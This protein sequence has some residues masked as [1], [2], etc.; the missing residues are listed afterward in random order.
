MDWNNFCNNIKEI[1]DLEK[2]KKSKVVNWE[3]TDKKILINY[4]IANDKLMQFTYTNAQFFK[5]YRK[6]Q[7]D[8]ELRIVNEKYYEVPVS[9]KNGHFSMIYMYD[10]VIGKEYKDGENNLQYKIDKPSEQF[11][12][13]IIELRIKPNSVMMFRRLLIIERE[14]KFK[15]GV[16][17]QTIFDLLKII[18]RDYITLKI[19]AMQEQSKTKFEN[20]ADALIFS[21]NYNTDIG[22]RQTYDLE[23]VHE[24]RMDNRF[25]NED[26][27]KIS[28]PRRIYKK[29]L[30]EQYNMASITE[31]PFIQYLC[32]YHIL[33]HFYEFVYKEQL[34]KIVKEQLTSPSF[35]IKKDK[36]IMK[37]IDIV[38]GKIKNDKENFD[39][40]ELEALELVL[41]KY[42]D[43]DDLKDKIRNI[44]SQLVN[45]YD[46]EKID[47]SRGIPINFNDKDNL[48]KNIAKRIYFTRNALVHYKSND[49]TQKE[50]GI[51]RP[52][53]D[54]KE[55][56][57]EV[58]LI[59]IL[60][61]EI[62]IKN[63]EI[64]E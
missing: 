58:P 17:K 52:F 6:M 57:K 32:Y 16:E 41:K 5:D 8:T 60:A 63:S 7:D 10:R 39:V 11:F 25:R 36:E 14:Y 40:D 2:Y 53:N 47:F 9:I 33:E 35:S 29:E 59:R 44:N 61:E 20:L 48:C 21:I 38:K 19:Y 62:I 37:L 54:R 24:R 22:I 13:K 42:I 45:Y 1:L 55:L 27:D 56:V 28:P 46:K 51:Y 18:Y 4:Y 50:K 12:L 64:L 3:I 26:I 30:I 34:V 49:L 23:N 15:D 31:E 43:I